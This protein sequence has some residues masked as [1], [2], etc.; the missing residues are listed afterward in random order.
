MPSRFENPRQPRNPSLRSTAHGCGSPMT[1][2]HPRIDDGSSR[3]RGWARL[4]LLLALTALI[5]ALV[6]AGTAH[7]KLPKEFFGIAW[8]SATSMQDL[9]K[10]KKA[11]V[12]T[13]RISLPWNKVQPAKG[14]YAWG[15]VDGRVRALATNGI[16]PLI[17]IYGAP[18]W[19]TKSSYP[20]TPPLKGKA[21][22]AFKRF[23]KK[24]VRRYKKRGQF[25][26]ENPNVPTMPVKAWQIWNE[27]NLPK[28]F[29]RK[30][31]S[32]LKLVKNAP[33]KYAKLVKTASKGL[34]KAD[35]KA[36]LVLAGLSGNPKKTK[37]LPH[38]FMKKF[39]KARKIKKHFDAAALHPY[40]ESISQYKSRLKK[41]RRVMDK[42]GAK[43]R[44]IWLTEVGWGS[45]KRN[46]KGLNKGVKGQARILK[47]AFK[48]TL[49]KRKKW[50]IE[51]LFWFDWRDYPPGPRPACG[52]C[53][54]A[55]LLNI[56][57]TR[58]PA[59]KQFKKFTRKQRGGKRRG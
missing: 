20:G 3:S 53:P 49:K 32:P 46:D 18:K 58:K 54:Y 27:P 16:R 26:E 29:A 39:L 35:K 17:A 55:G 11:K 31:T 9:E 30:G 12:H 38:K 25:W 14:A 41:L 44:D 1:D 33:K 36:K 4:S 21:K 34:N 59:M 52:F 2:G 28:Y 43:K 57:G 37:D 8:G 6:P 15:P 42:K 40:A 22:K 48:L 45:G 50:N 47:K 5:V 56:D 23:V 24:A 7:A 51:R 13:E 19:A 10:Q